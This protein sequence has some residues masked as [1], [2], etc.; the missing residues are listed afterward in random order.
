M[1]YGYFEARKREYV[2][3]RPDTPL[4]WYNYIRNDRYVGMISNTGGGTSYYEEPRFRTVLRYRYNN[5]PRDR[6]GRYVYLRDMDSGDYWS[7][8]WSPVQK[9]LA[10]FRYRCRV[11]LNYQVIEGAYAGIWAS[12]TY[13]V[14]PDANAEIW[15][16]SL[17]NASK[18]PRRLRSYSYAEFAVWGVLR[19]LLNLDNN[20]RC[21]RMAFED[22][23]IIHSTWNDIGTGLDAMHW[24]RAYAFMA[25]TV[26]PDGWHVERDTF[27]GN[28]RSE[29]NPVIVESGELPR[30]AANGG[31][32][33]GCLIHNHTLA[34]G[35]TGE[36]AYV[37]SAADTRDEAEAASRQYRSLEACLEA[38]EAVKA[39]WRRQLSLLQA[40]TPDADFDI[41][42]NVFNQYQSAITSYLS[43]SLSPYR[44][45]TGGG[46][47]FRDTAQDLMGSCHALAPFAKSRLELLMRNQHA[48]GIATHN[49][50]PLTGEG[51]GRDF[52]DDHLWLPLSVCHY[53][54]ETGDLAFAEQPIPFKDAE[55]ASVYEHLMRSLAATW[56][57]RGKHGLPQIGHADWNDGLNPQ[58][59]E[60][61]SV[62]NAMLFCAA[63]REVEELARRLGKPQDAEVVAGRRREIAGL[64]NE[65]AWDGNWYR[66]I[67]YPEGG[68]IGGREQPGRHG[69]IFIEPQPWAVIGGVADNER[70]LKALDAVHQH[71]FTEYGIRLLNEPFPDYDPQIG[72]ISIVL[73]GT[74]ENG[75]VFC[76]T[77][78][79]VIVAECILGRGQRAYEY[80]K[81][82]A[83]GSKNRIAGVHGAEPY[84]YSQHIYLPPHQPAGRA[85]NPWLTGTAAWSML[86]LSQ[87][88]L[89]IRP[90][91]DGL[92]IDPC[93]PA[94]WKEFRVQRVFRGARYEVRVRNPHGL[95]KG[96]KSL[97]LDGKELAGNLLPPQPAGSSHRALA[98]M[99]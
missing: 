49:I 94:E 10:R 97:R 3:T 93:I 63:A 67:L 40:K 51:G 45:G 7:I 32:P 82:I 96:V 4:A 69:Y 65:L 64:A 26:P 9:P 87:W 76:H 72:S 85:A 16:V 34:A 61:E 75:S 24:V 46:I 15:L 19:D 35:E 22:G 59:M 42:H 48:D 12:V 73:P 36:Y 29:A 56:R 52:Y 6:P 17:K 27:I 31:W 70:G 95:E 50:Y 11:G 89:G 88:I 74:K 18:K 2:I 81:A 80:Y 71:L 55:P 5:V 99:G 79:W 38:L 68:Y 92:R 53:L 98:V 58:S 8:N 84:V 1:Q 37:I 91:W 77:N 21:T 60:A 30:Y 86:A 44:W 39:T 54:K 25:A 33:L 57:L 23:A 62:F 13:Y 90:D 47:G 43:R 83:Y 41:A 14:A 66:R 20:P 28:S 78:P